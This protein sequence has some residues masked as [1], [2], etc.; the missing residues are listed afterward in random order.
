MYSVVRRIHSSNLASISSSHSPLSAKLYSICVYRSVQKFRRIISSPVPI[1][2]N[3]GILGRAVVGCPSY[4]HLQVWCLSAPL[5]HICLQTLFHV[6]L[7]IPS[8]FCQQ[9][10]QACAHIRNRRHTLEG[11]SRLFVECTPPSWCLS[12]L[13]HHLCLLNFFPCVCIDPFKI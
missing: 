4:A 2:Y 9:N 5:N 8:R 12:A 3:R 13:F 11:C 6:S 7:S 1:S 10:Q